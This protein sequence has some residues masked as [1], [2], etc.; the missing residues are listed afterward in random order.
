MSETIEALTAMREVQIVSLREMARPDKAAACRRREMLQRLEVFDPEIEITLE[1]KGAF[2]CQCPVNGMTDTAD[3]IFYYRP[4]K[5]I[6]ELASFRY[7]L[8][9][10]FRLTALAHE[11]AVSLIWH[12]LRAALEIHSVAGFDLQMIFAP[13]EGVDMKVRKTQASTAV[14]HRNRHFV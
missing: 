1:V 6:L 10:A 7:Y 9:N 3:V 2:T 12:D 13:V 5:Y 8:A 14:G 4:A 11:D